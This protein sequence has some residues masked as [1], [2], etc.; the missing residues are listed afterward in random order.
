[1]NLYIVDFFILWFNA[2]LYHVFGEKGKKNIY[3]LSCLQLLLIPI[4]RSPIDATWPDS[5]KY[6]TFFSS[7]SS[8][9]SWELAMKLGWE[10][11]IIALS[12]VIG[13]FSNTPQTYII[14]FGFLILIPVFVMIWKYSYYPCVSLLIFCSMK[15]LTATSIYRQWCAIAI[16]MYSIKFIYERKFKSFVLLVLLA[17]LFHRTALL[18]L[19]VYFIYKMKVTINQIMI[20][21][22]T[23]IGLIF[24]GKNLLPILNNF[25]R[26]KESLSY[27]G[28]ISLYV[29]LWLVV[30]FSYFFCRRKMNDD[31]YRVPFNAVLVAATLQSIS[32]TFSNW[33][34]AILYFSIF[35]IILLPN[36]L[37]YYIN[38][39]DHLSKRSTIPIEFAFLSLMFIW[40]LIDL[41]D[42][43]IAAWQ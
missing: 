35:L 11:G 3:I 26:T 43:Y 34:R 7:F 39:E 29:V 31:L 16:L 15:L 20:A 19:V 9:M 37:Y 1:M 14:V 5:P 33:S 24:V 42:G 25:A 27:N 10:P 12:K 32:F 22:F 6:L 30:F 41:P 4:C 36:T 17:F 13:Y 23:S 38:N 2:F 40:L 18:F 8:S 21:F 28:G